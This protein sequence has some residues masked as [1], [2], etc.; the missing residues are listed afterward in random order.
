MEPRLGHG[1]GRGRK[2]RVSINDG[3]VDGLRDGKKKEKRVKGGA[4]EGDLEPKA[5]KGCTPGG[6]KTI[7]RVVSEEET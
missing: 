3:H 5:L 7:T 4:D 6:L 2:G 1:G